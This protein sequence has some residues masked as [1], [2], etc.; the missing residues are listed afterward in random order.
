MENID[1]ARILLLRLR[2][3][4]L[5]AFE[6]L[7]RSFKS[8]LLSM[9]LF[10]RLVT[11]DDL[12]TAGNLET[13]IQTSKWGILD[14]HLV[15]HSDLVQTAHLSNLVFATCRVWD[16]TST[17]V[18][19][20]PPCGAKYTKVHILGYSIIIGDYMQL[21]E[22]LVPCVPIFMS[23]PRSHDSAAGA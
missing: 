6:L 3:F 23:S 5:A 10:L 19:F 11:V 16:S 2:F 9:A 22:Y 15:Q 8:F 18:V 21:S 17:M 12:L 4:E 14:E 13:S 20:Q 1:L 7:T